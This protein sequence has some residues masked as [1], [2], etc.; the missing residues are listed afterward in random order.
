MMVEAAQR[1]H[2]LWFC[3]QGELDVCPDF[4][5]KWAV[6]KAVRGRPLA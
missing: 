4:H 5:P 6:L 3:E 2:E 1:G